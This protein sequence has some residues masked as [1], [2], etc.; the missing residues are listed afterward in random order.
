[1]DR[2]VYASFDRF[3]APKGAAVHIEAFARRK[4]AFCDRFVFEVNGLPSVEWKYHYPAVAD[5]RELLRKLR[6]MEDACLAAAD[7]V[8]T[9]SRVTADYLSGRGV[10]PGRIRVI[11][12]GV[13]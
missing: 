2:I 3:P 8:V 5:D 4:G 7:L 9:V 1:M 11:P 10:D 12:N 6:A 13:D